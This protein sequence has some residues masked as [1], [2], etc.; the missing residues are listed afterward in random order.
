MYQQAIGDTLCGVTTPPPT[1]SGWYPDNTQP[2]TDRFFDGRQWTDQTRPSGGAA[3]AAPPVPPQGQAKKRRKKWP[4]VVAIIGV[5][6]VIGAIASAASPKNDTAKPAPVA[7]SPTPVRRTSQSVTSTPKTTAKPAPT[8]SQSSISR[9]LG[10]KDASGDVTI[11]KPTSDGYTVTAPVTVTN[12][13]S[14]RSDYF[15]DIS[16][17]SKDGKTQYDTTTVFSESVEPGQTA[18]EDGT[19]FKA[20]SIPSGA[21]VVAKSIQR[22]PSL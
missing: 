10:S 21:V 15:I 1:P 2:N 20:T 22:S 18:K 8:T 19:F 16:L 9:G 14:K 17:E 3:F 11:G 5:L 12:H 4:W 6:V 13:S 7:S